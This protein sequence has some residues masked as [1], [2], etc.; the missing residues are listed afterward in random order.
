MFSVVDFVLNGA[1]ARRRRT[2]KQYKHIY[3]GAR[4]RLCL[5]LPLR[6]LS[7]EC[8]CLR[9]RAR[10]SSCLEVSAYLQASRQRRA[11]W[12][13][14]GR[15]VWPRASWIQTWFCACLSPTLLQLRRF[16]IVSLFSFFLKRPSFVRFYTVNTVI[17]NL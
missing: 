4:N 2:T 17:S 5:C 13:F 14:T 15:P 3:K 9:V 10:H 6:E 8:V 11:A 16:H 1:C 12:H 7:R